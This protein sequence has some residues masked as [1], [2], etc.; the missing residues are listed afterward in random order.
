MPEK[1]LNFQIREYR[2]TQIF[3]YYAADHPQG[4][5]TEKLVSITQKDG[6][7]VGE[8][9]LI[10]GLVGGGY[11]LMKVI[12]DDYGVLY[13][14]EDKLLAVLTFGEDERAA[15]CCTGLINKRGLEKL[16]ITT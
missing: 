9:V 7:E 10:P 13:A 11:H 4:I 14:E 12:K 2:G 3:K 8:L 5:D 1:T 6:L 16:K 15:W